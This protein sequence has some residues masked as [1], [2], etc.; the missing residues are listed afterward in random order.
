M[1]TF[2]GMAEILSQVLEY[3]YAQFLAFLPFILFCLD[4]RGGFVLLTS[5]TVTL[6]CNR[7]TQDRLL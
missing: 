5:V 1:F 6:I 3:L 2:P 4:T 7:K